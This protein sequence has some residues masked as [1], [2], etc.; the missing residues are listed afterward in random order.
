MLYNKMSSYDSI[1]K[2]L[3]LSFLHFK[4]KTGGILNGYT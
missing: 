3:I 1:R 4:E 2:Y